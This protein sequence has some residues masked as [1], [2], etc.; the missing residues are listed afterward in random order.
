[1]I[2]K[3]LR[4]LFFLAIGLVILA[5]VVLSH[6][7]AAPKQAAEIP[8]EDL[9][10]KTDKPP[11][12]KWNYL[13]YKDIPP[14]YYD[15]ILYYNSTEIRLEGS[16]F[17][18]TVFVRDGVVHKV[19]SINDVLKTVL[20]ETPGGFIDMKPDKNGMSVMYISFSK[21]EAT[22]NFS[23]YRATDGNYIL[24]G[25]AE[26]IFDGKKYPVVAST[27]G[28]NCLLLFSMSEEQHRKTIKDVAPGWQL[29]PS[30]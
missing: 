23:F 4:F 16:F 25:K 26:I 14:K 17:E 12:S 21:N 20:I 22:Y 6:G 11:L 15:S 9:L 2:R 10:L 13:N 3:I 27:V 7:C 19:D 18:R 8:K 30:Y 1:M 28:G 24:N 5:L 29:G